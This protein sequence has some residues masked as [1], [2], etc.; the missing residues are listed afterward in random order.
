MSEFED[1]DL[2]IAVTGRLPTI[3]KSAAAIH[4]T[5]KGRVAFTIVLGLMIGFVYTIVAIVNGWT[6]WEMISAP[7]IWVVV[8]LASYVGGYLSGKSSS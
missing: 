2:P 1:P 7:F 6:T 3:E 8:V 4:E 5:W